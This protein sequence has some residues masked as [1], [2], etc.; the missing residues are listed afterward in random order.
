[1]PTRHGGHCAYVSAQSGDERFWAEQRIV[2]F[3]EAIWKE[4]V[5]TKGKAVEMGVPAQRSSSF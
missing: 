4:D 1:V 3:C 5:R 2:D